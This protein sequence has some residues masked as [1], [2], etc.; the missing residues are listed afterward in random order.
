MCRNIKTLHNFAP[1]ATNDEI[2]ASS[3]QFVRKLAGFTKPSHANEDAFNRAVDEVAH[4]AHHLLEALVTNSP[5]RDREAEALKA[6]ARSA[7]R[8]GAVAANGMGIVID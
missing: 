8:F 3:L 2:R 4:A 7:K 1:P 6:K 5:P